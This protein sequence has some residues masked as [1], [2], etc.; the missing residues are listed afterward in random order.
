MLL[1]Y[2]RLSQLRFGQLMQ[3]YAEGTAENGAEMYPHLSPN[4]Q[5]LRAE[6]DFYV[7]L[8][9]GFFTQSGDLYCVWE[10]NG[11]YISALRLQRSHRMQW[12]SCMPYSP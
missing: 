11:S 1:I 3:V 4:E 5:I 9:T 2:D 7:Y 10:E 8:Q 12:E 6:Q